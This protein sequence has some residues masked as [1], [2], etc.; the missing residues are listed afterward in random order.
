MPVSAHGVASARKPNPNWHKKM[1][2][3]GSLMEKSTGSLAI[4]IASS[5]TPVMGM[6][7]SFISPSVLL[8]DYF[9]LELDMLVQWLSVP[10]G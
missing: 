6:D 8:H 5:R 2:I 10:P 3:V 1:E 7:L 4:G 9:I